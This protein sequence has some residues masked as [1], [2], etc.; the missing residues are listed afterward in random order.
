[1]IEHGKCTATKNV[2]I[3]EY[4]NSFLE[5][6]KRETGYLRFTPYMVWVIGQ[7]QYMY[8]EIDGYY[9]LYNWINI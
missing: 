3:Y 9:D 5:L 6:Y 1:M 8:T 7:N 4:G 2:L